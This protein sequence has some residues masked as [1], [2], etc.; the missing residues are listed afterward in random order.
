MWSYQA[1]MFVYPFT[2]H[3]LQPVVSYYIITT[4]TKDTWKAPYACY[5]QGDF[6]NFYI[7]LHLAALPTSS[8]TIIVSWFMKRT[9]S[10]NDLN[11][12][13][14]KPGTWSVRNTFELKMWRIQLEALLSIQYL[15]SKVLHWQHSFDNSEWR[16]FIIN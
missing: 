1:T 12:W 14:V 11:N 5:I 9:V 7:A 4:I 3:E 6:T 15:I 13:R 16:I 8:K 2:K 10:L